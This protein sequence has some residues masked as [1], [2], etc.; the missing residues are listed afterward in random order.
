MTTK[1]TS[2]KV[3]YPELSYRIIE[4]AFEVFNKLGSGFQEKYY[5]RAFAR[6][7]KLLGIK[8]EKEKSVNIVYGEN[9]LGKYLLDFIIDH[10]IAVEL[11]ACPKLGYTDVKQI[12]NYLKTGNYKLAVIN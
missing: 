12:L 10:K 6:K 8:Y 11:K 1:T 4:T 2:D 3:I 7:L 9:S 5:Q